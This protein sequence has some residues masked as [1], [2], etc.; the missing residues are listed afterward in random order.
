MKNLSLMTLAVGMLL[1]NLAMA[2]GSGDCPKHD[3]SGRDEKPKV[4]QLAKTVNPKPNIVAVKPVSSS[5]AGVDG[6]E[7]RE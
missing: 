4:L 1:S 5:N 2:T 6:Q 7:Y 3:Q